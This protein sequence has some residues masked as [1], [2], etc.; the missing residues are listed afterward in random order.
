MM[1]C[2]GGKTQK[3][4]SHRHTRFSGLPLLPTL[5]S[6]S[7]STKSFQKRKIHDGNGPDPDRKLTDRKHSEIPELVPSNLTSTRVPRGSEFAGYFPVLSPSG[8]RFSP[9]FGLGF[10]RIRFSRARGC[11]FP[12]RFPQNARLLFPSFFLRLLEARFVSVAHFSFL[13]S[14]HCQDSDENPQEGR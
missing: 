5:I 13:P 14:R 8:T 9:I 7:L 11:S 3:K 10:P 12:R 1:Q 4:I 6:L 2:H